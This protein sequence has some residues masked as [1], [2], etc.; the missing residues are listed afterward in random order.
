[1]RRKTAFYRARANGFL[2]ITRYTLRHF[3]ATRVRAVVLENGQRVPREQGQIW[4]GHVQGDTTVIYE[5]HDPD[6][7][8]ECAE[9]ADIMMRQLDATAKR[10]IL[11]SACAGKGNLEVID[12]GRS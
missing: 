3:M 8:A 7:L 2:E 11:P 4:L 12:R 1:M 6:Y 10:D 5:H 9:A